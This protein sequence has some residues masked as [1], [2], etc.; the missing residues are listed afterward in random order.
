[1]LNN[2]RQQRCLH[3]NVAAFLLL[4][5]LGRYISL[6]TQIVIPFLVSAIVVI[7]QAWVAYNTQLSGNTVIVVTL[8]SSGLLGWVTAAMTS[9]TYALATYLP[10]VY[11]QV[12]LSST[13]LSSYRKSCIEMEQ[14]SLGSICVGNSP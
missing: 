11:I 5:P 14:P 6:Q 13:K 3:R 2:P 7:I 10:P 9:A 1:M 4:L 8:L 12:P